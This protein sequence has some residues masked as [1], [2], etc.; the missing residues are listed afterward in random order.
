MAPKAAAVKSAVNKPSKPGTSDGE[1]EAKKR[2]TFTPEEQQTHNAHTL[3]KRIAEGKVV[4]ASAE[5]IADAKIA[6]DVYKGLTKEDRLEFA[7][8][9]EASKGSKQY[10][11]VRT[12]AETLRAQKRTTEGVIENYYTRTHE[13]V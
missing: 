12:F 7:K 10:N 11:W 1:S 8:K 4:K 5:N 3:M 2:R 13:H 6:L 9:V